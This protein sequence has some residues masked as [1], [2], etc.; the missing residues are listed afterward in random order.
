MASR[1]K[2]FK[3]ISDKAALE[4]ALKRVGE[5]RAPGKY[6]LH[7]A[8]AEEARALMADG[9]SAGGA[10]GTAGGGKRSRESTP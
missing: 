10:A 3:V 2:D 6:F 7:D 9:S 5:F 1:I 8:C 4:R